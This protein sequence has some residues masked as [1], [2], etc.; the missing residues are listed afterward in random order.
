MNIIVQ[1]FGGTSVADIERIKRVAKRVK[2]EYTRGNKVAVI[3]SAMAGQTDQLIQ[4]VRQCSLLPDNKEYDAVTA[5]GEQITSGLLAITL[6]SLGLPAR[7]W[8]GWQ[9]PIHTSDVHKNA[10]ITDIETQNLMQ[11]FENGE[12]AVI[13][14]FQGITAQNRIATLGRSGSDT[15]AVAVAA[16]LKAQRCDIYTDVDGIYTCDPRIVPKA[17][18]L[19]KISYEEM[20]EF[21]SLG[22]KILQPRSVGLA[23][24]YH[25]P[26]RVLSSFEKEENYN[27]H[28]G[29]YVV[30][31]DDVLEQKIVSGIAFN[32]NEAKITLRRVIDRP[33]IAGTIFGAMAAAGINVD[34]IVQNTAKEDQVTDLTFTIERADLERC[35]QL[36]EEQRADLG[37]TALYSDEHVAKISIIG[38][39]MRSNAGVA[40]LMFKTLAEKGINIQVISTSEIKVS[41]LIA[42]E[43]LELAT[44]ALHTAYGL[45]A[46]VED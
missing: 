4:Y 21:A 37:Y 28:I 10:Q 8:L 41:V 32:R 43:Y 30:N 19:N 5:S 16:K 38:V 35:L 33:G 1:K 17:Q 25:V 15:S 39:G 14:G 9:I 7:S 46:I 13:S 24:R 29:T 42:E 11:S 2:A 36:L 22:A 3:V 44:R 23:M 18:K 34:M 31:E 12:V 20:L 45:D 6:Q 40:Q 27:D 26:L